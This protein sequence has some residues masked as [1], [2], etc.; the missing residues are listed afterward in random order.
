MVVADSFISRVLNGKELI[1]LVKLITAICSYVLDT[2][3]N[4]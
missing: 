4:S 3:I 2:R 1:N